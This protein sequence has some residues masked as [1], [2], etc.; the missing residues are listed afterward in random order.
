[1]LSS[2]E[3]ATYDEDMIMY[4]V[5]HD[6]LEPNPVDKYVITEYCRNNPDK[7]LHAVTPTRFRKTRF[8]SCT[9]FPPIH[10]VTHPRRYNAVHETP[11]HAEYQIINLILKNITPL[12]KHSVLQNPVNT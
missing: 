8:G 11:M 9:P 5:E 1:M 2:T 12:I 3:Y 7:Y 6:E 4:D 10:S